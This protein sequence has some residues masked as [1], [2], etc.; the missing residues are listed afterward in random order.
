MILGFTLRASLLGSMPS[1][2]VRSDETRPEKQ[3]KQPLIDIIKSG[4]CRDPTQ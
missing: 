4:K 1:V 3:E 2:N